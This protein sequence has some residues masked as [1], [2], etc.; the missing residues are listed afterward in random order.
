MLVDRAA[1]LDALEWAWWLNSWSLP[2]GKGGPYDFMYG[3]K[4]TYGL[5][6]ALAGKAHVYQH[7][8][9]P[10]GGVFTHRDALQWKPDAKQ[11]GRFVVFLLWCVSVLR[12]L[13]ALSLL[14]LL[15][16]TKKP[17]PHNQPTNK[18]TTTKQ[19]THH[20]R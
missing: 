2:G 20:K 5:G 1:H 7:A 8:P 19:T 9:L 15:P 12:A 18:H 10:P 14:P 17:P 16:T 6:F 11:V 13:C 4:D 3:D